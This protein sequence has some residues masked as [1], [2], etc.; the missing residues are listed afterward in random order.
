MAQS[1]QGETTE[2]E[3]RKQSLGEAL[4]KI[5]HHTSSKLPNQKAPAQ[6]L[7]AVEETLDGGKGDDGKEDRNPTEYLMAMQS[8]LASATNASTNS[9]S[10]RSGS[11]GSNKNNNNSSS[12]LLPSTMYLLTLITP[13]VAPGV[14]RSQMSNLIEPLSIV[15][16]TPYPTASSQLAEGHAALLRSAMGVLQQLLLAL[17]PDKPTLSSHL[18]LRGC[19]NSTLRLCM[20]ARPKVRR[21][22]QE[23]VGKVL[24]T[25]ENAKAH[26]YAAKTAEWAISALEEVNVSSSIA[27]QI[28]APTFD[29][30]T[31]R[32]AQP[33]IA[34]AERQKRVDGG[35][36][37]TGI[38]VCGFLKQLAPVLPN[39]SISSLS[40]N[41]LRLIS[42]KNPFLSTAAFE[43]FESL[44]KI[45]RPTSEILPNPRLLLDESAPRHSTKKVNTN[46]IAQTLDA[47]C[48]S[49]VAPNFNDI[50]L[51]PAYLRALENTMI[52][53]S[54][55]ESG[56]P[57]WT[58]MP[59]VWNSITIMAFSTKSKASRDSPQTRA[60]GRDALSALARYCI[61]D[62]AIE[63]AL[64]AKQTGQKDDDLLNIISFFED[65][66]DRQALRYSHSR[67]E[68][69]STLA[70][71]MSRLRY[72]PA[73]SSS[74]SSSSSTARRVDPAAKELL[75]P[76]VSIVGD[77]R[78]QPNFEH[79]EQAD[80]VIGGAIE[81]C[82]PALVLEVLP[83]NLFGEND[84]TNGRAWLLPLMRTRITNTELNHFVTF[85]VPLSESLFNKR[86]EAEELDSNGKPRAPVQAK[87]FEA[88]TEQIWAL[89][90]GYCD[91]PI[92]MI[93]VLQKDFVELLANVLYS[94]ST[95]R[96]SICRGFQLLVERNAS[97]ANSAA[98]S[99]MLESQFGVT[100]A[101][102]KANMDHLT[103]IAPNLLAV[104]FN[105]FSQSSGGS[106]GYL[107]DCML[108][109]LGIMT[110]EEICKTYEKIVTMLEQSLP[111]LVPAKDREVGPG[112]V[113]PVPHTMLDLLI[114][115]V[116]FLDPA[117]DGSKLFELAIDDK[118]LACRDAGLQK[119]AYR[120]LAR[121]MEGKRGVQILKVGEGKAGRL[122]ELLEKLQKT[123]EN[124]VAGAKR[125]RTALLGSL[126]PL[127]PQS[128]LHFLPSIIPEA[129]LATKEVN[130]G[131]REL[132]YNLLVEMGRKME[133]GGQLKRH[134]VEGN[135]G[136]KGE[137]GAEEEEEERM[138]GNEDEE[139]KEDIVEAS[140]NEYVTMIAAGLAGTSPHMVSA[141]ITAMARLVYEFHQKLPLSTLK[142][143]VS[144]L[145]VFLASPNREIVKST[146][147]FVKV[148]MVSLPANAIEDTLPTI[149][150][151]LLSDD[152]HHR[153]HFKA[154]IRHIFERLLRR[155]GYEK[156]EAMT[157]EQNRKLLVNIRKRK[158]RAKRKKVTQMEGGGDEENDDDED[159][160]GMGAGQRTM[161]SYGADAF[162][163]AIYGSE[164]DLSNTDEEGD[165]DDEKAGSRG[166]SKI[167]GGQQ[168]GSR[169]AKRRG[170]DAEG[171]E[172]LLQDDDQPMDLLDRSVA[173]SGRMT[174]R[175][176]KMLQKNQKR[177]PGQ[178][179]RQFDLDEATGRMLIDEP[180]TGEGGEGAQSIDVDGVG[181]AFLDK[182]RGTHG[183]TSKDMVMRINK[184]NKRNRAA[185]DELEQEQMDLEELQFQQQQQ[186]ATIA[187][188]ADKKQQG[189]RGEKSAIGA[190]YK[191]RKAGGDIKR[192]QTNPYAYVPLNQIG[193][194][195]KKSNVKILTK[196]KRRRV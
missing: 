180:A 192:G 34:A 172:Y 29:K 59:A 74:S 57:A 144:T 28:K 27:T 86:A 42:Q 54:R 71:L 20:D 145:E 64:L 70:T 23:L 120:V 114:L 132:A 1:L 82:G 143:L 97:L 76:I 4:A 100:S 124:V 156:I 160:G 110:K 62:Q 135:S 85:M 154:K 6:L 122:Q 98:P 164:S 88:L 102:G 35:N 68:I 22:A 184:N 5:R 189:K 186:H 60:A 13:F 55:V 138:T 166:R 146:L 79:R 113:P 155:F 83:L 45:G 12:T 173:A 94:Q 195:N 161:K 37:N 194:K 65:S 2:A 24:E 66:L 69:L 75:L 121:L 32:A 93:E 196:E 26:P 17:A 78:S 10:T 112:S 191:A 158:E 80:A 30:K 127:I 111:T 47:L 126:V 90:S 179:A 170:G 25:E 190:E 187:G 115:L 147:G 175:D 48:S 40:T 33:E 178:E 53:Y 148:V 41:L 96:P 84:L 7:V 11:S 163:E 3:Q 67:P 38:W 129:V 157:D 91:L 49:T 51:I 119:K 188:A 125:D 58:R 104:L 43:V 46:S 141:T 137:S 15:L 162:E 9:D 140:L 165:A 131:A 19:W 181:R 109:Y 8:M 103:S 106:R 77:L 152:N 95:L 87:V 185:D 193:S 159:T 153:Q 73:R 171:Q 56:A 63:A 81:V 133:L 101:Q 177:L 142:E 134:L 44:F 176:A 92:D 16:S 136:S 150:R 167:R 61:P 105:I 183:L 18:Q 72:R 31:G 21:R 52:S 89:F 149:V 128:E 182:E 108:A 50:Q 99:E 118:F 36:A 14:L 168:G 39:K 169:G 116:N 117:T 151:G 130:Q 139:M 107:A 123:T 174:A